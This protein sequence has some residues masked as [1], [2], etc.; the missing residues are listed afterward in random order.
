MKLGWLLALYIL[1]LPV[2]VRTPFGLRLA[3]SDLFLLL[4]LLLH[5]G[6]LRIQRHHVSIW[7]Y[8]LLL[9]FALG[10]LTAAWQTGTITTYALLQKDLGLLLLLA[11]Y[12][13]LAW[14]ASSWA[15][16]KQM[17][18]LFI[19]TVAVQNAV[20]IAAFF[21]GLQLPIL[22]E[23][24]GRLSGFLI[25]PNAY[26]GLLVT[27]F[28]VHALPLCR[29]T[30]LIGGRLGTLTTLSLSLGLLL[31]F[32]RSAWIGL[33]V[34][35]LVLLASR[36][37]MFLR[38]AGQLALAAGAVLLY[39]GEAYLQVIET[40]A[41]RSSP[42]EA[43]LSYL[44]DGLGHFADQPVFGMGVGVFQERYGAIIHNTPA[45]MLI[46]FGLVGFVGL[47]LFILWF[48][49]RGIGA[50]WLDAGHNR[51]ARP[52]LLGL[53]LAH[54]AMLGLSLGIEALYQRHWWFVLALLAA[55]AGLVRQER[56]PHLRGGKT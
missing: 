25:D 2:Q 43:R 41:T 32:S 31:T 50:Y 46:E 30:P 51:E 47:A 49:V 33:G 12:C 27:A 26:G 55:A 53:L 34:I 18:Q 11:G 5:L 36:P 22:N 6:Q 1:F 48:F 17:L 3:P 10:T 13:L 20:A 37:A 56:H 35:L 28:A 4:M 39:K 40:M 45:W 44:Y 7:H 19:A 29:G 23:F 42:V 16:V 24:Q 54:V 9:I 52:L 38:L 21:S 15:R 8:G 14:Q